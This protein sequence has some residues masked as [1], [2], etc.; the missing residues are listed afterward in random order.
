MA[1]GSTPRWVQN[2][3]SS[4]EMNA[5][6]TSF[7]IAVMGT[8]MRRSVASSEI[9]WALPAYTRLITRG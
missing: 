2:F 9:S 6:D 5:P 7:G 4:A 1:A 3:W 8:K